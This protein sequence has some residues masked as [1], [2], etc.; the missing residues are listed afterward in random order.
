VAHV[1]DSVE[2]TA[3]VVWLQDG[4]V[5]VGCVDLPAPCPPNGVCHCPACHVADYADLALDFY[6]PR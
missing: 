5:C 1:P 2:S 4:P 3:M 6:P